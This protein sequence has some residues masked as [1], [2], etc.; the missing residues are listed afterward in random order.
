MPAAFNVDSLSSNVPG[1]YFQK[2]DHGLLSWLPA[3]ERVATIAY[4]FVT[5]EELKPGTPFAFQE[6]ESLPFASPKRRKLSQ[7]TPVQAQKAKVKGNEVLTTTKASSKQAWS[8]QHLSR[9][10]NDIQ[11]VRESLQID[12]ERQANSDEEE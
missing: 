1:W 9:S 3:Q 7:R 10:E 2:E 5:E 8:M 12:R 4:G 11:Q 6:K